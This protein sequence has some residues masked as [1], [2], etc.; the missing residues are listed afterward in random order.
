MK[1]KKGLDDAAGR[2]ANRDDPKAKGSA[3]GPIPSMLYGISA[4]SYDRRWGFALADVL[5]AASDTEQSQRGG[6][7][8]R[9]FLH[10]SRPLVVTSRSLLA[11]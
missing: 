1:I 7:C 8:E 9:E 10:S 4:L 3:G 5:R 6:H 11:R 2:P